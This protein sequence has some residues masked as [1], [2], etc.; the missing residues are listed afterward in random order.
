MHDKFD[1]LAK[2]VAKAVTRRAFRRFSFGLA[3]MAG[4]GLPAKRH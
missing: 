4:F 3:A 2:G 1:Q